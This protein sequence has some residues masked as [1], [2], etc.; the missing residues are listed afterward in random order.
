MIKACGP[1]YIHVSNK[2]SWNKMLSVC[3]YNM[4]INCYNETVE[5][6]NEWQEDGIRIYKGKGNKSKCSNERGINT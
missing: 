3:T 6:S 1:D 4:I 2:I 5:F